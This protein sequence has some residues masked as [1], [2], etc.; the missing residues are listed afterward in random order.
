MCGKTDNV[1][2]SH[3]MPKAIYRLFAKAAEGSPNAVVI[4]KTTSVQTSNQVT[5]PLL[6]GECEAMFS[7]R[8]EAWVMKHMCRSAT[9]WRLRDIFSG[10]LDRLVNDRFPTA[11][12]QGANYNA[13]AYFA[14]SIFWRASAHIWAFGPE[15]IGGINLGP[16]YE[17]EFSEFLL[18]N[19]DFPQDATLIVAVSNLNEPVMLAYPPHGNNMRR[20]HQYAFYVPGIR[21]HLFLGAAVPIRIREACIVHSPEHWVLCGDVD[22]IPFDLALN[23]VARTKRVLSLADNVKARTGRTV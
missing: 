23:A 21:F 9:E 3:Y 2:K 13:L 7:I 16:R 17:V 11:S 22:S 4:T 1:S 12:I 8:G 10:S 19:A 14:A 15:K 18:G 20:Y 6:C 5:A